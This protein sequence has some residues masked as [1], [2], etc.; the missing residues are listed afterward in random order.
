M[1]RVVPRVV[2]HHFVTSRHVCEQETRRLIRKDGKKRRRLTT[3]VSLFWGQKYCHLSARWGQPMRL[4]GQ[5][6]R[7]RRPVI[8]DDDDDEQH[9]TG[10]SMTDVATG[11]LIS[12]SGRATSLRPPGGAG[13]SRH[14][15]LGRYCAASQS[16]N[17]TCRRYFHV[18]TSH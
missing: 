17:H 11:W 14:P 1:E 2:A 15:S 6:H 3:S 5:S 12:D 10:K 13:C 9:R 16:T 7:R 18:M 4:I 8:T